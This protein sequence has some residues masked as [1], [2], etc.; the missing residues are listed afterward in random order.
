MNIDP[1][2]SVTAAVLDLLT[3]DGDLFLA[4]GTNLFRGL[5][6]VLIVWFG[7]QTALSSADRHRMIMSCSETA[8]ARTASRDLP[9]PT[10]DPSI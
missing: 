10:S 3:R 1:F 6:V 5:A 9:G 4:L 7:A 2:A 8:E